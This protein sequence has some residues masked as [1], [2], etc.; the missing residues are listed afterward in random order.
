MSTAVQSHTISVAGHDLHY[1]EAGDSGPPVVLLHGGIVDAAHLSWGAVIEPL[2]ETHHVYALDMLGYGRSDI[3][4]IE[5]TTDRHVELLGGF[6]DAVGLDRAALVGISLGGGVALGFALRNP[7]RVDR[8]VL[9]DSYGLGRELPNGLLT[10]VLAQVPVFNRVSI[11]L[12]KRSRALARAS[13]GSIVYDMDTV[14]EDVVDAFY[15][16]LQRPGVATAFRSWR[17][18][19]VTRSG[20]RT[21]YTDRLGEVETPTLLLH[22]AEDELFPPKWS[23]RAA[24]RMSNAECEV[25]E[26]V[27]HWLPREK[28]ALCVKLVRDFLEREG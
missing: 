26:D 6:L 11:G 7:D 16:Q 13:L 4:D 5:Y 15:D 23:E 8:L 17:K 14:T 27:A 21:V 19:E 28:P 22:G 9:V 20:Y 18:H 1:L 12:L 24:V 2:A 3:P 10:Y 25:I